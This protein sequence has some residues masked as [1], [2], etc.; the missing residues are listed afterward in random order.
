MKKIFKGSVMGWLLLFLVDAAFA[1]DSL[2]I[3]VSCTIP[4]I[5]GINAPPFLERESI[6]TQEDLIKHPQNVES[7]E[8]IEDAIPTFIQEDIEKEIILT[9]R[10]TSSIIVRTIYSR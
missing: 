7:Q 6:K 9:D 3:S 10:K 8:R 5:P 4:A 2:S 1:G